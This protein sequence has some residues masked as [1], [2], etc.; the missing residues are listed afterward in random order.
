[1]PHCLLDDVNESVL[2]DIPRSV[3]M[4]ITIYSDIPGSDNMKKLE[5]DC[6]VLDMVYL[7]GRDSIIKLFIEVEYINGEEGVLNVGEGEGIM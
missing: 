4:S 3:G 6:D 1:M 2:S 5:T 7:E